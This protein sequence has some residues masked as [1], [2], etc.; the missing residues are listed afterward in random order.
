MY[1]KTVDIFSYLDTCMLIVKLISWIISAGVA[2]HP[3]THVLQVGIRIAIPKQKN[4]IMVERETISPMSR[5]TALIRGTKVVVIRGPAESNV[6]VKERLEVVPG[7][8]SNAKNFHSQSYDRPFLSLIGFSIS[9]R[10]RENI[11]NDENGVVTAS[12]SVDCCST[13]VIE[14]RISDLFLMIGSM[15]SRFELKHTNYQDHVR[16]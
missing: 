3:R 10:T 7:F 14:A 15:A 4:S 2:N 1:I 9:M 8:V 16:V 5:K 12:A 6:F 13:F 11:F